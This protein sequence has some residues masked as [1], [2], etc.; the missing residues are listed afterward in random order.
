M[1]QKIWH[2]NRLLRVNRSIGIPEVL[3]PQLIHA[4]KFALEQCPSNSCGEAAQRAGARHGAAA[5][6]PSFL[7]LLC[8]QSYPG[9]DQLVGK[10]N[11]QQGHTRLRDDVS[12]L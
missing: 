1:Q 4:D 9:S 2:M 12:L 6:F 5:M 11:E 7:Q 10:K 8:A 3:V